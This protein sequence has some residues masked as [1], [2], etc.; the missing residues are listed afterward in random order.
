MLN[1]Q[2]TGFRET[3]TLRQLTNKTAIPEFQ[4][5]LEKMGFLEDGRP[6]KK[7]GDGSALLF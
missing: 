4:A 2:T 1:Y 6:T 5:W 3:A 7:T